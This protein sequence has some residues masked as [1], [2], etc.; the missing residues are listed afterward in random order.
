MKPLLILILACGLICA[1]AWAETNY[2][3]DDM[4]ITMRTG[5]GISYKIIAMVRSGQK[6]EIVEPDAEWSKVRLLENNKEG[7]VLTRYLTANQPSR[8]ALERLQQEHQDL[9]DQAAA[10]IKEITRLKKENHDLTAMLESKNNELDQLKSAYETLKTESAEFIDLK[11]KFKETNAKLS[12][13]TQ[14]ADRLEANFSKL[15]LHQNIRWFLS[16]A[17]V[18]LV[19]FIIGFST[20][21]Q[22]RRSSLL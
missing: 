15:Q 16:G 7:W 2:I 21:R 17:G 5:P 1:T 22:R 18:L 14:K 20:R 8:L 3:T 10:P 6:V 4:K 13:Q 11:S 9:L 12:E 19:G